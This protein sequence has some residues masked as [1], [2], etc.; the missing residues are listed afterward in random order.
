MIYFLTFL[1][2]TVYAEHKFHH[3]QVFLEQIKKSEQG[4]KIY[5]HF[6]ANCHAPK[7]IIPVNAP[8]LGKIDD[9]QSRV[10]QP[11]SLL[12]QHVDEGYNAMPA[13]GG[14]FECSEEALRA[15]IFYLIPK[16]LHS[17]LK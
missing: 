6:C 17:S 10:K 3:P 4:E 13:R 2:C 5:S 15:A 12:Y 14:C 9:W 1:P 16:S 7:P 8:L 11:F